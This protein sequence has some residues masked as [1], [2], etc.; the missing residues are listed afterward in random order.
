MFAVASVAAAAEVTVKEADGRVILSN[1]YIAVVVEPNGGMYVP[2]ATDLAT[3]KEILHGLKLNFPYFEHGIKTNQT[4]GYRI[5]RNQDGGVTVAM[6][7]RFC[8]HQGPKE[9]ERYGRFAERSLSEFVTLRPGEALFEFRGRVDNPTPLRRSYRLWDRYLLPCNDETR[10]ILPVSHGIEHSA[11]WILPW[12]IREVTDPVSQQKAMADLSIRKTWTSYGRQPTQ[13]F[14]F[15]SDHG[16]MGA[17]YPDEGINRLRISNPANDPGMK[18]YC[19]PGMTICEPWGGT[20]VV[21]EDP[22]GFIDGFVPCEMTHVYYMAAGIGEISYADWNVAV[23]FDRGEPA[24]V[25]V[26]TPRTLGTMTV[27]ALDG[28]KVVAQGT[29]V[30]SP[31]K[32]VKVNVP[33]GLKRVAVRVRPA[34]AVESAGTYQT[35]LLPVEIKNKSDRYEQTKA[36]C[37]PGKRIDYVELQEHSNHR[38]IPAAMSAIGKAAGLLKSDSKDIPALESTANACYRIG[39]FAKAVELADRVL[40]ID[41]ANEHAFHVKGM[42]A[43]EQ[44]NT[45]D[46]RNLL[47]KAGIQAHYVRALLALQKGDTKQAIALL[48]EMVKARPQA[49]R[50]RLVLTSL[51]ARNGRS[52]ETLKA[53]QALADENPAY[54]EA[55]EVLSRVAAL[56]G[57]KIRADQ[58]AQVRDELLRNNPD[59]ERQLKLFQAEMDNGKWVFVGRYS[60]PLPQP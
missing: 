11:N 27:E 58:A 14:G 13:Y 43:L 51:Y 48:E 28:D 59:A 34:D 29:G 57:D 3:G 54:S 41:A 47:A 39:D 35:P 21:F 23:C 18:V 45:D 50:P 5:I 33:A 49:Y 46:A 56:A 38:G 53:A 30:L 9:I 52:A 37:D 44:G 31:G 19:A 36:V 24:S 4:A 7:M 16:F 2:E 60:Q 25:Q 26:A 6:N 8:H 40:G 12:P 15:W 55:F 1:E 22:G 20:T 10:F 32:V 17:W 42:I